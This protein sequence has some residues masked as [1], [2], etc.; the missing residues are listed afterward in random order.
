MCKK[1]LI[2]VIFITFVISFRV[3][4]GQDSLKVDSLLDI[5][6]EKCIEYHNDID[7]VFWSSFEEFKTIDLLWQTGEIPRSQ[8]EEI[9]LD[10]GR[11]PALRWHIAEFLKDAPDIL[12][13]VLSDGTD[14][15][16]VRQRAAERLLGT[17][18]PIAKDALFNVTQ[19]PSL[20]FWAM[21]SLS[22]SKD[23]R[24]ISSALDSLQSPSIKTKRAAIAFLRNVGDASALP[25]LLSLY[26][27]AKT[28]KLNAKITKDRI[29]W[30]SVQGAVIIALGHLNDERALN[31]LIE[32]AKSD[33]FTL[34]MEAVEALGNLGSTAAIPTL[35]DIMT[36]E[37]EIN[38]FL[39]IESAEALVKIEDKS[40][41]DEIQTAKD[42]IH[43][44]RVKYEVESD[45]LE[46]KMQEAYDKLSAQ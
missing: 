36:Q 40:V 4:Y 20:W 23:K 43:N 30:E 28:K 44:F 46:V 45:F 41:L 21:R 27:D 7:T 11:E 14:N 25:P 8:F 31:V 32:E 5:I 3:A 1:S 38:P 6:E 12:T 16:K 22:Y 24:I 33:N 42:I 18:D 29:D 17:Q 39:R 10:K 15:I 19:E 26:G 37:E 9:F 13:Q 2:S 34:A 35:V